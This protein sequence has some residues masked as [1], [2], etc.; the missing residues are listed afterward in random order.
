MVNAALNKE[1]FLIRQAWIKI[2]IPGNMKPTGPFVSVAR[3]AK[4]NI[5]AYFLSK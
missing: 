3:D 5:I 2:I 4:I 1:K